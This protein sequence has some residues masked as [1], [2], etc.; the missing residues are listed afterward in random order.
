MKRS[1]IATLCL[2]LSVQPVPGFSQGTPLIELG[3]AVATGFSGTIAPPAEQVPETRQPIDETFIDRDGVS[4]RILDL[5]T[6]G[7]VWDGRA[8]SAAVR[9][10]F[11]AGQI[12]QVFGVTLDDAAEPNIYFAATSVYGLPIVGPDTD[13]NQLEDRLQKGQ[14]DAAFMAG[15][16]GPQHLGGGPGSIWRVDGLTGDVSLFANVLLDGDENPGPALGNLAFDADH[17]SI[18]ASDLSTGMIVRFNMDGDRLELFNHGSEGRI[19]AG[20][21]AI[22]YDPDT[23]L[24]ITSPAFDPE[25]PDTWGYTALK[26]QVWGVAVHDGRLYYAVFGDSQIWSVGLDAATGAF[27]RDPR[28]ELDVPKKPAKLP[29]TDIVFTEKGAMVLAQRGPVTSAYDYSGLAEPDNAR[30]YRYWLESPDDPATPSR[31][32][33]EPEEYPVGFGADNRRTEGGVDLEYGFASN[34]LI[35]M[36]TCEATLLTTGNDLRNDRDLA[37][38]LLLGG[39]L[40]I[41]GLQGIP[42]YPAKP[43]NTPPWNSYMIQLRAGADDASVTGH[44][45]DVAVYRRGC[46]AATLPYVSTYGG[47]GYPSDPP[48]VSEPPVDVIGDPGSCGDDACPEPEFFIKKTCEAGKVDPQTHKLVIDCKI[49]V[50][51]NGVP[52]TGNLNV[53]E[54]AIQKPGTPDATV[55]TSV[56]SSDPWA[57][58]QPPFAANDL[59]QCKIGFVPFDQLGN[60]S[61]INVTLTLPD[62]GAAVDFR[63][64]ADLSIGDQDLGQSCTDLTT[65]DKPQIDVSLTKT[66]EY[67]VA[68]EIGTFTLTVTNIGAPF[69]ATSALAIADTIPTGMKLSAQG[70]SDWSCLPIPVTGPATLLCSYNGS[71]TMGTGATSVLTFDSIVVGAGPFENCATVSPT[72][73][74]GLIDSNLDNNRAC[75]P[76]PLLPDGGGGGFDNP[77]TPPPLDMACGTNVIFVVDESH[78]IAESGA[79]GNIKSALI[80]AAS[81]FNAHG[82]QAAVVRF[83]NNAVVAYPMATGSFAT[84]NAG[85]NPNNG[86]GTNWE[87]GLLMAKS[88]LPSAN[89][90]IIFIT[91]GIPTAYLDANGAVVYTGDAVLATNEAITVVNDIYAL[92]TPI[93]GIGIGSV[94]THLNAL[95][96]TSSINSS[97]SGLSGVLTTF[98]QNACPDVYLGKRFFG[99]YFNFNGMTSDPQETVELR[100]T[101]S[102]AA[103]VTNLQVQDQLPAMFTNPVLTDPNLSLSGSTV[104]WFIP[105]LAAGATATV[106]FKVTISPVTPPTE[107]W[108]CTSNFAQVTAADQVLASIPNNMASALTGPVA[109]HDEASASVCVQNKVNDPGGDCGDPVLMVTKK[110]AFAEV[111]VPG[112]SPECKF[113]VTVKASCKAFSGPVLF[114]DGLSNGSASLGVPIIGITNTASPAICAWPSAWSSTTSP[115]T[116]AANISLAVNQSISFTVTVGAPMMP[117]SGY[118]NCFLADGKTPVPTDFAA[119]LAHVSPSSSVYG[120]LWGN[121]VP[122]SVAAPPQQAPVQEPEAE[123]CPSGT[124]KKGNACTPVAPVCK[125][126][127]KLNKA[128][129]ACICPKN[130]QARNGTCVQI[131]K[132]VP[133]TP[134]TCNA[135]AVPNKAGTAC[136]C[137]RGTI[138]VNKQCIGINI[139]PDTKPKPTPDPKPKPKPDTKAAPEGKSPLGTMLPGIILNIPS[140]RRDK[141]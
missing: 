54:L 81:I 80:N 25:D 135:P 33:A 111:C 55:I 56:S 9:K 121:C 116:C 4:A 103:A 107:N 66:Y 48:Y 41:D 124:E 139:T 128:R 87:A 92:G 17:Q 52:F 98:A 11:T 97:F 137:P 109:E 83:S 117:G 101:N 63:N 16:W 112:G 74:S 38:D 8:W 42:A 61:T 60:H 140:N 100:V 126:Q 36:S 115:S 30:L 70:G 105:S 125:A 69:D 110:T 96:G 26:R 79:A 15:L 40:T 129:T 45:G 39:P 58:D 64:C 20:L 18:F 24:E 19:A 35:D 53:S 72:P 122:F 65:D 91:D 95:L 3:N 2:V 10:T 99:R 7:F 102:S 12:G 120:G 23:A 94:S 106:T 34:G 46:G 113:T 22:E 28:W 37:D 57:C 68:R 82:A 50:S 104:T 136:V 93:V 14:A 59:P 86:G 138:A 89:T 75:A 131:D 88:L 132:V 90:V 49:D 108:T 71:G 84:V 6:P 47:A 1:A 76:V 43:L 13:G 32:I 62:E 119:A 130:T 31:W 134:I 51:S 133:K 123:D 141:P 118:K 27:L 5:G 114:G 77:G 29:V 85:Y 67:T 21:G 127:A 78:S 44:T 73:G